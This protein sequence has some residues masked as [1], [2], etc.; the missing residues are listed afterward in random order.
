MS[1]T[2]RMLSRRNRRRSG[3]PQCPVCRIKHSVGTAKNN[4]AVHWVEKHKDY[5]CKICGWSKK[6]YDKQLKEQEENK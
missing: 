4:G 6:K 3:K 1:K 5:K 2:Q